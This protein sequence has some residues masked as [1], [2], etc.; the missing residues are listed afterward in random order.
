MEGVRDFFR[1]FL[2]F[3]MLLP[4]AKIAAKL[5]LFFLDFMP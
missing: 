4:K 2:I 1:D 5:L 3:W